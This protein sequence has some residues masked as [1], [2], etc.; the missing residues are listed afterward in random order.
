MLLNYSAQLLAP[1]GNELR[2]NFCNSKYRLTLK[3]ASRLTRRTVPG[4][5]AV[6]A[7]YPAEAY[8]YKEKRLDL[9]E[10]II[11]Q[12]KYNR[13]MWATSQGLIGGVVEYGDLIVFDE[14][15][16][17][18]KND[19]QMFLYDDEYTVR[20]VI[21]NPDGV[22]LLPLNPDDRSIFIGEGEQL[23]RM[24]VVTHIVK[25]YANYRQQY[26]GYPVNVEQYIEA[27]M[28]YSKYLIDWWESTFYMWADGDSMLGDNIE[29]G[30]LL[31]VDKRARANI[32]DNDILV[33]CL[34]KEYTLKRH[35]TFGDSGELLPSNPDFPTIPIAKG[36]EGRP[37]GVLTAVVKKLL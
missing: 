9:N 25:K 14:S 20:R 1:T 5:W 7:G 18:K 19:W 31:I 34:D 16:H 13:C 6:P 37:W 22:E 12:K 3:V 15:L 23:E 4:G 26:G 21:Q 24:G 27:G 10:Y 11:R 28:D 35:R 33:F 32:K 29:D 30:D 8:N 17:P 2:M 36:N